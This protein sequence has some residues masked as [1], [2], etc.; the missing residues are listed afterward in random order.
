VVTIAR[1]AMSVTFPARLTLVGT[2]NPCSCGHKE[3]LQMPYR[4][5]SEEAPN[6]QDVAQLLGAHWHVTG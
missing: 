1:A 3:H 5:A 4:L 6:R 2:M